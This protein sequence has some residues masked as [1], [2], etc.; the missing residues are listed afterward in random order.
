MSE[1][2]GHSNQRRIRNPIHN[3][4]VD[5]S[6]YHLMNRWKQYRAI[7][8]RSWSLEWAGYAACVWCCVF[9]VMSFHWAVGGTV[10]LRTV[11]PGLQELAL[12]RD[13]GFVAILWIT[14]VLKVIGG[15]LALALVRSW[16]QTIPRRPLLAVAWIGCAVMVVHG[17]DFLIRGVLW[18]SGAITVPESVPRTVVRG[19]AV[20]WGLW[21]LLG[22]ILFGAAAW[23]YQ[24]TS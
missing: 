9:A 23:H 1:R 10:G 5:S 21:W 7:S 20:L 13:P 16:N 24:R 11:S 15:L 17:G 4:Y 12:T 19:Y 22:G 14:G 8:E 18:W 3:L 2:N 6:Q